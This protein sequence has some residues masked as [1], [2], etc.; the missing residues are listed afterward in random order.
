MLHIALL[1]V[2]LLACAGAAL[3]AFRWPGAK[4]AQALLLTLALSGLVVYRVIP[5][6]E[7]VDTTVY[8]PP[9]VGVKA[10]LRLGLW[11]QTQL[12]PRQ[13]QHPGISWLGRTLAGR[14]VIARPIKAFRPTPLSE[15]RLTGIRRNFKHR[16]GWKDAVATPFEPIALIVH[17]TEGEDEATA[18]A[19]FDNTTP[20][21]YLGG[22][23]THFSVGP[24]GEIY[25]YGPI[26]R[27]SKGQSGLDD[28]SIGVEIV[29]TASLWEV[30][31]HHPSTGSI[32][33]RWRQANQAQLLAT[34]DLLDTLRRHYA[35]PVDHIYSHE[36]LGHIRDR[37][38]SHPDY[39]W[40][41]RR[42]RDRVY[43][44]LDWTLDRHFQPEEHYSFL[45]PYDRQDPGRDVMEVL[46]GLL[47][48][49]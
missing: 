41:R 38:G 42:I 12:P 35:I 43:L 39:E 28:A 33:T 8:P 27:I 5:M 20:A 15:F 36:D 11:A 31:G 17:S 40:L 47:A 45:E 1:T 34:A 6:P 2:I 16:F 22:I 30:D 10:A 24:R 32:I 25:Q 7:P 9:I 23:W 19:I 46:R 44:S 26:D 4:L 18:F 14:K 21:Q 37:K 48:D 49:S 29:G 13:P 3:V